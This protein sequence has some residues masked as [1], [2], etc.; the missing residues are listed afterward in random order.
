MYKTNFP[1]GKCYGKK[2]K[3]NHSVD[4]QVQTMLRE[5][6]ILLLKNVWWVDLAQ[7]LDLLIP[8]QQD[9]VMGR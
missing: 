5:V 9:L 3:R 7:L 4:F 8:P 2:K 6:L 1:S